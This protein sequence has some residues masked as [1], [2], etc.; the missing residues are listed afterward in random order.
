M[1]EQPAS[2]SY[3]VKL[4]PTEAELNLIA[5]LRQVRGMCVYDA[6]SKTL[7]IAGNPEYCNGKR[8]AQQKA[9]NFWIPIDTG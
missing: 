3:I 6:E 8:Y 4:Q 5:R 9:G 1:S 2:M 7:W